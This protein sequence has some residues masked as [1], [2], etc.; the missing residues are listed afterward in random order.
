M[1]RKSRT[2]KQLRAFL[3]VV[4][5]YRSSMEI[6]AEETAVL[7]PATSR[8]APNT[9]A[10]TSEMDQ[11]FCN[12]CGIVSMSSELVIPVA[13]DVLSLV[14]DASRRGLDAIVQVEREGQRKAA[15]FYS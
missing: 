10:G 15:A 1:Y 8:R 4:I 12:I 2:K 5:F 14:S 13:N 7:T 3:G 6:L 11:A 9:V